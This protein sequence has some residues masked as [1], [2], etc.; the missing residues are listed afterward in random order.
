VLAAT[1]S[2][3]HLV[4]LK[5]IAALAPVLVE[6]LQ[7]MGDP[8]DGTMPLIASLYAAA[9]RSGVRSLMDGVPADC[10]FVTGG[11]DRRLARRGRLLSAWR[12]RR[13]YPELRRAPSL[14]KL[15]AASTLLAV[16]LPESWLQGRRI[17]KEDRAYQQDLIEPSLI[18]PDFAERVNLRQRYR[19]Y[20]Q[21]M[22]DTYRWSADG[23]GQ[24][25]AG[26]AYITAAMERYERV[27]AHFSVEPRPPFTDRELIE[28]QAWVPWHL[29][30]RDGRQKWILRKAMAGQLPEPVVWR[31]GKEHIGWK[32]NCALMRCEPSL[33]ESAWQSPYL[34]SCLHTGSLDAAREAWQR[35]RDEKVLEKLHA[36][37]L[38]GLWYA[39]ELQAAL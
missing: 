15:H 11:Y 9:G 38:L 20:C 30:V 6:W 23:A 1:S 18:H 17:R 7:H 16:W 4:D 2:V 8:F 10:F 35:Q 34:R 3:G 37:T 31:V 27:A 14:L 21:N 28:F 33:P 24:S 12:I 22:A 29:R 32:F 13:D 36:P 25:C 26:V 5:D 39:N 19:R